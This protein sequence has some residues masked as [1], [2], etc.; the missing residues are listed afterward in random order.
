MNDLLETRWRE[1]LN[2]TSFKCDRGDGI[3]CF[4]DDKDESNRVY[5]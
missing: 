1:L 5:V 3:F 4:F 2:Y